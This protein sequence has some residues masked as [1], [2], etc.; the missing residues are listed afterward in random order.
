MLIFFL[1]CLGWAQGL[2]SCTC[3]IDIKLLSIYLG[4][5]ICQFEM[6]EVLPQPAEAIKAYLDSHVQEAT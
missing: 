6:Q 2:T 4:V 1:H 5:S 3:L